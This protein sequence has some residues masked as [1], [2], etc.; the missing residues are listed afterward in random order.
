M[1]PNLN[2][3][4]IHVFKKYT[5]NTGRMHNHVNSS[6]PINFKRNMLWEFKR[7]N[8]NAHKLQFNIFRNT[9]EF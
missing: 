2:I 6:F 1:S 8:L 4:I 7:I 3:T 9:S 5:K